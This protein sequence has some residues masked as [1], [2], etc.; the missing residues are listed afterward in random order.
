MEK[1]KIIEILAH[2]SELMLRASQDAIELSVDAGLFMADL[3]DCYFELAEIGALSFALNE[4]ACKLE[5]KLESL[6]EGLRE[7]NNL[8]ADRLLGL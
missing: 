4:L 8:E 7:P 1:T 5:N 2:H 6:L 3:R